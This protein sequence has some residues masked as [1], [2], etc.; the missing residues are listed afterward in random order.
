MNKRSDIAFTPA[1]KEAQ[2]ARGS[3]DGYQRA[4][5][6]R[7]WPNT[8]TDELAAFIADRDSLYIGTSSAAG[9]PY[10][11]HRGGPKGFLVPLDEHRL[12]FA[13]YSG[14]RQ[15]IT[16][17]NLSAHYRAFIFLMD[18][19]ARHRIKLWGRAHFV[20]DDAE[21]LATVTPADYAAT[22]ERVFVFHIEAWDR[23]CPQHI[24]AR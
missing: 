19:N 15:Y 24:T 11:Q 14:N 3:R 6:R 18:Y 23:N 9:Q 2:R 20:E 4:L 22:P 12:A 16:L 13:H 8:I 5:S 1:V 17:G 7:D 10:I 21:L